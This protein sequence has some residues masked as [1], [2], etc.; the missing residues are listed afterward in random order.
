MRYITWMGRNL[1]GG[2]PYPLLSQRVPSPRRSLRSLRGTD[3]MPERA[4]KP[5]GDAFGAEEGVVEAEGE[6]IGHAGDVVDGPTGGV[7]VV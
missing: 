4:E 2:A 6:A 3:L 5:L 7:C 1:E